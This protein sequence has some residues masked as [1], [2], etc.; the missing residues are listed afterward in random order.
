[1]PA[2]RCRST[3]FAVAVLTGAVA[4]AA[5]TAPPRNRLAHE[6]S[7]Y[8]RQHASNPVD[9]YPWGPEAFD[10]ARR[11]NK[12]IF[13]SIGYSTC[14]WCHVMERESF[15]RADVA[16]QLNAAFVCI[17]VDREERPDVD[18]IYLTFVH[19]LNGAGG[20]PLN[21]WLTPELKPFFGGTYFAPEDRPGQPSFPAVLTRIATLWQ[22]QEATI[23]ERSDTMLAALQAPPPRRADESGPTLRD[24]R[25][26]ALNETAQAFDPRHG[27][28]EEAP[29]FPQPSLLQFLL[30]VRAF[31][32]EPAEREMAWQMITTTLREMAAG[33]IHDQLG[34][35]FHRYSVDA[36]WRVPHFEKM[37]YDQAQ[38]ALVYLAAG[39]WA[40]AADHLPVA[41]RTLDYVRR[42]L[43]GSA[44]GFFAAE[45]AE[46]VSGE[47][48]GPRAE[49]AF[50]VW[51]EAEIVAQLGEADRAVVRRAY[52]IRPDGNAGTELPGQNVLARAESDAAVAAALGRPLTEVRQTLETARQQLFT[53][54]EHRPLPAVD[55]TVITAWNGLMISAFAR[56]AQVLGEPEYA[57][58]AERAAAF[59]R[60]EAFDAGTG[61]LARTTRAG[62][63]DTRGFA[64]DYAFLVQGLL[65]LYETTF[66]VGW[67]EWSIQL[68]EKQLELFFDADGGGFFASAADDATLVLRLK[69][70]HDGA[71]PSANSVSVRNL[72]RLAAMLH[73]DDWHRLAQQTVEAFRPQL[74][75]EPS[76]LPALSAAASW[77]DGSSQQV[78]IHGE[79]GAAS[80]RR[81]LAEVWSRPPTRQVL[82]RIDDRSHAFFA[83]RVPMV[84]EL[85]QPAPAQAV[86]YVCRGF[87]CQ[88]PTSDP[89]VLV[90]LLGADADTSW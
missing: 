49:G 13:L 71:E 27:G 76:A 9:W 59:L 21:V 85:P 35:G 48:T 54:R 16:E 53:T 67:L 81:M 32:P 10:K 28:F 23:R 55:T 50:Y 3:L 7:P 30:E 58:V 65:D 66:D 24:L 6:T 79:A 57:A 88:L 46:S 38:L 18:R 70:E 41:R 34:G 11:E 77:L 52:G 61:E 83:A 26:R 56:G 20:W 64:E 31:S 12:P 40:D 84:A 69:E 80:T 78:L 14:H 37:L 44:G 5:P 39:Q 63:R 90:K 33:G 15:A 43:T 47:A 87:T 1:V 25:Q 89:E 2:H 75:H 86:A 29:K 60:R 68:Q 19:A 36:Q 8:L 22:T 4:F 82:V 42:R 72:A 51:S 45:D 62:R 74:E 73:R 17:K